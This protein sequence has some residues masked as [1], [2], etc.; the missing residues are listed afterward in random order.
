MS[1]AMVEAVLIGVV[2]VIAVIGGILLI[3]AVVAMSR[4]GSYNK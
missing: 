2:T 1:A 4:G 3:A